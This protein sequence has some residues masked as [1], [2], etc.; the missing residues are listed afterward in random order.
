MPVLLEVC[1]GFDPHRGCIWLF[2][3]FLK[4]GTSSSL[5][6]YWLDQGTD[7]SVLKLPIGLCHKFAEIKCWKALL[8]KIRHKCGRM[9]RRRP[10]RYPSVGAS[11]G[12]R[13]P[14]E[15]I[16]IIKS[17]SLFRTR[18]IKQI[19]KD[20]KSNI[21]N[22][23]TARYTFKISVLVFNRIVFVHIFKNHQQQD[24]IHIRQIIFIICWIMC[25]FPIKR[26][27]NLVLY[28]FTLKQLL[29]NFRKHL[30][31]ITKRCNLLTGLRHIAVITL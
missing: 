6:K 18:V 15:E 16:Y 4:Q 14:K 27:L 3:C 29:I 1:C 20:Q 7:S 17:H 24:F 9:H 23:W 8:L 25:A 26:R 13:K 5:L 19:I 22:V 31:F 28:S 2:R 12:A 21:L 10:L 30:T 11:W